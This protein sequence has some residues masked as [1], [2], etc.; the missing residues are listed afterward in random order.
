VILKDPF[1]KNLFQMA[2]EFSRYFLTNRVLAEQYFTKFL[3]RKGVENPEN[4]VVTKRVSHKSW[5]LNDPNYV[6]LLENKHLFEEFFSRHKIKVVRSL[7]HN[8]NTLFFRNQDVLQIN[9]FQEF[10]SFLAPL[11]TEKSRTKSVF[12]KPNEKSCGGKGIFKITEEDLRSDKEKMTAVYNEVMKGD[13]LIQDTVIQHDEINKLNPCCIN[14]IRMDTFTNSNIES[15]AFSSFIRIGI[16]NAYLDNVSSGGVFCGINFEKGT[17]KPVVFSNFSHGKGVAY[18]EHPNTGV[19]FDG[20]QIPFYK[21][22]RKLAEEA[23]QL[24]PQIRLIG[25]D[26]AIQ[27]DGPV[28][29]EGNNHPGITYS[30]ISQNGFRNNPVFME[31]YDEISG[32]N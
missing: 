14:T 16:N 10:K 5:D 29:I 11:V 25:W 31:L 1:R 15:R 8:K 18:T 13:F 22:A 9:S 17:L 30:E 7:A 12:I 21:E 19:K 27:P 28:I 4:Y 32:L 6:T 24:V 3:Y 26:I 2:V 20:F 23:A